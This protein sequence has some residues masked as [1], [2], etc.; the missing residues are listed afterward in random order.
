MNTLY[1]V[2]IYTHTY[3][4]IYVYYRTIYHEGAGCPLIKEV[5][6]PNPTGGRSLASL[7]RFRTDAASFPV[8]ASQEPFRAKAYRWVFM[9]GFQG[10]EFR[11]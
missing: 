7:F 4:H 9:P 5:H 3:I 11:L 6:G 8:I 10:L 2:S 1:V